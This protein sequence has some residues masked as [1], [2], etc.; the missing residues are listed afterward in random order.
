MG[1]VEILKIL[2]KGDKLTSA[3]IAA[4]ST[5]SDVAVKMAIKRLLKDVTGGLQFRFL[6]EEEK[7]ER[8]GHNIGCRIHIYWL[9]K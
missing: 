7:I 6:T 9:N 2:D 3:E 8:Y 5:T 1:A 4:Q